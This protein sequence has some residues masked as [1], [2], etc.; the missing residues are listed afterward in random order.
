MLARHQVLGILFI[1][2]LGP[3]NLRANVKNERNQVEPTSFVWKSKRTYYF[4][5]LKEK[6]DQTFLDECIQHVRIIDKHTISVPTDPR[7]IF[8]STFPPPADLIAFWRN[9][10]RPLQMR[11]EPQLCESPYKR[12][13]PIF[14]TDGCQLPK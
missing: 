2:I 6:I 9:I 7:E 5:S 10:D 12:K 3:L 14:L 4:S 13:K 1:F 8:I 11:Q